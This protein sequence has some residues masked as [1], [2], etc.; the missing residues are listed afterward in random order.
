V[1]QSIS[2]NEPSG[3]R[4]G[5]EGSFNWLPKRDASGGLATT[6]D[7]ALLCSRSFANSA[8]FADN[9]LAIE[10]LFLCSSRA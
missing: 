3:E 9:S 10:S 4:E 7:S 6:T 2:I 1:E 5:A 8:F